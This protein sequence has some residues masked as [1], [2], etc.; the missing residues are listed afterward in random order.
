MKFR[1][2]CTSS[3]GFLLML[4]FLSPCMYSWSQININDPADKDQFD[5]SVSEINETWFAGT[6]KL[7]DRRVSITGK[8]TA[9]NVIIEHAWGPEGD[10]YS[11]YFHYYVIYKANKIIYYST[12]KYHRHIYSKPGQQGNLKTPD[13]EWIGP[14]ML[15]HFE[16][17]AYHPS[18]NEAIDYKLE[19]YPVYENEKETAKLIRLYNEKYHKK[20]ALNEFTNDRIFFMNIPDTSGHPDSF[21]NVHYDRYIKATDSMKIDTLRSWLSSPVIEIQLYGMRG[22]KYLEDYG[23]KPT[24]SDLKLFKAIRS[25]EGGVLFFDGESWEVRPMSEII[26]RY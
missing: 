21:R 6:C 26:L 14:V 1:L 18:E 20:P 12:L 11:N 15:T 24:S 25:R 22:L 19:R 23:Y 16:F 10:L 2:R 13:T 7:L 8:Y 5:V 17:T 4:L 3:F 9:R